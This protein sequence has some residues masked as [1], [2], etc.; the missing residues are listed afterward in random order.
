MICSECAEKDERVQANPSQA[1][2]GKCSHCEQWGWLLKLVEVSQP[3]IESELRRKLKRAN[4]ENE[5][6]RQVIKF[7]RDALG[8]LGEQFIKLST[9]LKEKDV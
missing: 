3:E 6:L 5:E 2:W 9:L 4:R 1:V 8:N 7:Q